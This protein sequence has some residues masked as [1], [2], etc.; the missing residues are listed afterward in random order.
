MVVVW[1]L[2]AIDTILVAT[3]SVLP[4]DVPVA[5]FIQSVPWGPVTLVFDAINLTGGYPQAALGV[6]VVVVLFIWQRRSGYLTAIGAISSLLDNLLKELLAR[7]RPTSALVHILEPAPGYSYPSGHAVFFTW[8]SFMLAFFLGPHVRPRY[9]WLLW[10]GAGVVIAL[11]C[12]ARV[13]AGAHWPSD[14]AGGVL[15]A[16][17]WSTFVLWLAERWP[18]LPRWKWFQRGARPPEGQPRNQ[19]RADSR[20]PK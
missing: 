12:V 3:N 2:F 1:A 5:T 6:L 8:L 17:G 11:T 20:V 18:P 19:P 7:Q 13:W 15:L 9:R 4:V 14:V 10:A 16:L